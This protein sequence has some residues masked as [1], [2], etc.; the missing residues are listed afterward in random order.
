[1]KLPLRL[2]YTASIAEVVDIFA[3]NYQD[4][5]FKTVHEYVPDKAIISTE[6]YQFFSGYPAPGQGCSEKNPWQSV[7]L[8]DQAIGEMIWTLKVCQRSKDSMRL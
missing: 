6:A 8:N 4:P 1:M 2:I 3:L 5:W 7:T